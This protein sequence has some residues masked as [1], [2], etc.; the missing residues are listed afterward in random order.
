MNATEYQKQAARTLID[1]PGFDIDDDNM[2]ILWNALGL[3]GEAGEVAEMVKKGILHQHGLFYEKMAKE[4]GDCLWYIAALCTKMELDM[5]E[6]MAANIEK[7]KIRYPDGFSSADSV[8][9]VDTK[10]LDRRTE[11]DMITDLYFGLELREQCPNCGGKGTEYVAVGDDVEVE[12][13]FCS[14]EAHEILE[15][16]HDNFMVIVDESLRLQGYDLEQLSKEIT[17]LIAE[18]REKWSDQL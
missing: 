5:G 1:A 8:A 16:H 6:V 7:L 10:R 2:M 11:L 9:R 14:N 18:C 12:A 13:C 15:R 4:L 17:D 3:A